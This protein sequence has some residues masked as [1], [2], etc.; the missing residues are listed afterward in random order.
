MALAL[1]VAACYM[2]GAS[3]WLL[4]ASVVSWFPI[5]LAWEFLFSRIVSTRFEKYGGSEKPKGYGH[6]L[7]GK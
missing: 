6:N 7:I 3:L 1:T 2:F 5:F 4:A